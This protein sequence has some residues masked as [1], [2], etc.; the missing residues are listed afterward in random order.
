MRINQPSSWS[1]FNTPED[2]Y[3]Y[4]F[5]TLDIPIG[6]KLI[7]VTV[8]LTEGQN[9]SM[10]DIQARNHFKN[11]I[12]KLLA[13]H[14]LEN[15]LVETTQYVDKL[16]YTKRV[17]VRCYLAPNDQIKILRTHYDI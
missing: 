8:A 7:T 15:N 10:T 9:L 16:D 1:A 13:T 12:A 5:K 17:N 11:E 6:G 2:E 14:M 3:D 4:T